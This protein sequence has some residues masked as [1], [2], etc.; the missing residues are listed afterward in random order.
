MDLNRP[1]RAL[2][3]ATLALLGLLDCGRCPVLAAVPN[4]AVALGENPPVEADRSH[5]RLRL[6][7]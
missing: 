1:L 3:T 5:S 6:I 4:V 2:V 7:I